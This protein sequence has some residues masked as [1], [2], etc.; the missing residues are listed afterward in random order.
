[1]PEFKQNRGYKMKGTDLYDKVQ[2]PNGN[3]FYMKKK[4]D[5][6]PKKG[7][8]REVKGK[9][10]YPGELRSQALA[11][12]ARGHMLSDPMDK[13]KPGKLISP[14][15]HAKSDAVKAG[16][17]NTG[18][19]DPKA[20]DTTGQISGHSKYAGSTATRSTKPD[21]RFANALDKTLD[22][23]TIKGSKKSLPASKTKKQKRQ[24]KR[25]AR[26]NK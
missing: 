23:R 3:G 18:I 26:K 6:E 22:E 19:K 9:R 16:M 10:A 14:E 5:T 1:M 24:G 13:I 2:K 20:F 21:A 25:A 17:A 4:G 7:N 11:R 15:R 12:E 8:Y